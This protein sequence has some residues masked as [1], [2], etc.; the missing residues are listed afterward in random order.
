LD[1]TQLGTTGGARP[2]GA[3]S[4]GVRVDWG[5]SQRPVRIDCGLS[6]TAGQARLWLVSY[7]GSEVFCHCANETN[8]HWQAVV[9]IFQLLCYRYAVPPY[10]PSKY[11]RRGLFIDGISAVTAVGLLRSFGNVILL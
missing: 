5:L 4:T 1:A 2:T 9:L 3:F 6:Y 8:V 7:I 10:R 11:Q